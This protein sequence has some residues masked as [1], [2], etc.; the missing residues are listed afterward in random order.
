V[1]LGVAGAVLSLLAAGA[2]LAQTHPQL[3]PTRDVDVT[4]RVTQAGRTVEERVRWL[5]AEQVQRVDSSGPIY[6]IVDHKSRRLTLVNIAKRTVLTM[7]APRQ[8]ALDPDSDAAFTNAG[9]ASV[10][11]LPCTEW[12]M[13]AGG[14]KRLCVTADGVML[15]VQDGGSTLAEATAVQY[16]Q[17]DPASFQVPADF[18][19]MPPP[20]AAPEPPGAGALQPQ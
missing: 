14:A 8:S 13:P 18:Q 9:Q 15:R 6:M 1:R 10:A 2:A 17:S 5:A 3:I 7:D 19:N 4:Y 16:G 11:G 20:A 12:L